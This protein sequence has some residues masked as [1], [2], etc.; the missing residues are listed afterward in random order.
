MAHMRQQNGV[1]WV[2]DSS[3]RFQPGHKLATGRPP[4]S[5]KQSVKDMCWQSIN[6]VA[7]LIFNLPEDEMHLWIRS[8]IHTLSLAERAYLET[9]TG[10]LGD[11]EV[12]DHETG[13]KVRRTANLGVIEAILDRIVGKQLKIDSGNTEKDPVI[14]K[15]YDLSPGNVRKEIDRMIKNR[16]TVQDEFKRIEGSKGE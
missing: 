5:G 3:G 11:A 6:K 2:R 4:D 1:K 16:Q 12:I 8:N 15:L 7:W 9:A 10:G 13:Q 14:E